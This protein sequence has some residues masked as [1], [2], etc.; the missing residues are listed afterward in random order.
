MAFHPLFSRF[1]I[2]YPAMPTSTTV[3]VLK[4]GGIAIIPTDTLY[5]VVA[6]AWNKKAVARLYLL[7]RKTSGKPFIILI[8]NPE[9]LREFG[10]TPTAFE[11]DILK[12][13]WP[14]KV[15]VVFPCKRKDMTYLH[16]GTH[17]LAFRLPS[18][19]RLVALLKKTGPLLAPSANPDGALP[20]TTIAEAKRYFGDKVDC[21]ES[22]GRRM[23]GKPSTIISLE[24]EQVK[25]LR[26]GA[27]S[28][29]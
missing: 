5:G 6:M 8:Q 1:G 12:K 18:G 21:Y 9:Q 13:V 19:Q 22:A 14:G 10:I 15:S 23:T 26:E 20:A 2:L 7:R 24:D 17:S 25:I 3:K 4:G 16:L 28:I 27:V 29:V 11:T